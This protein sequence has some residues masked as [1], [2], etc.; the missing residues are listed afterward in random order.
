MWIRV[1]L[2]AHAEIAATRAGL[3]L[4]AAGSLS[5]ATFPKG[6]LLDSSCVR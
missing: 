3:T 2:K 4:I 5:V 1:V 6:H